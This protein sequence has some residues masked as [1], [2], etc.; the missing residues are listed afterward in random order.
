[1]P[2]HSLLVLGGIGSG[3][4]EYAE[5]VLAG[6]SGH[7]R[8]PPPESGDPAR[9][10][11]L[12]S[13]AK[14]DEILL[15]TG[16]ESWL[17]PGQDHLDHAA[18]VLAP[19]VRGC[20]ARLV[21]VS[22]EVGLATTPTTAANRSLAGALGALNRAV[23]A[24]VDAVVLVVAGQPVW[25][26]GTPIGPGGPVV[27]TAPASP[28][29]AAPDLAAL[30]ALPMPDEESRRA[31]TARLA[32]LGPVSLGALAGVVSYAAGTQGQ[33][34]PS[35]WQQVRV[36]VLVGDHAG[37]ASAG[38]PGSARLARQLRAG[39]SPLAQLAGPVGARVQ[40]VEA[41]GAG[42]IED[43][44]AM[45][46]D[47]VEAAFGYG[48]RLAQQAVDEGDELLVLGTIGDG[49][50]TAAAAVTA[51]LAPNSEPAALLARV[52]TEDGLIDDAAWMRRCAAVR[53]AVHRAKTGSRTGGRAVLAEL[54]GP[55]L[56]TAT[57]ILLGAAARRTPV[58]L[59]G[60][61][62]AAAALVARNLASQ[63]RH[64]CL[65][66]DHGGHPTVVRAVEVLGLTPW[67]DLRLELGEGTTALAALPL[68]NAALTLA[69][70]LP[71]GAR[72][73]APVPA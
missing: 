62:G 17:P 51:V 60:P 33:P 41:A 59:D 48:W 30:R 47:Q 9:L 36:L 24:A 2:W 50:E 45:A 16:L 31:A 54:G 44:P 40:L 11:S 32:G 20:P 57:G 39:T 15:V 28:A 49:A 3:H 12:L 10:A 35:P 42:P 64:W 37:A 56:A 69:G 34:V 25:L 65:V 1:M 52:R 18:A 14:P 8:V 71:A 29:G 19:A 72:T 5:S 58:L 67:L 26:K 66:P 22:A 6:P 61:V 73:G 4:Q 68:L 27:S 7:R 21:L 38:A 63:S 13:E 46:E 43:Q 70:T 23:A 55:D 53:D